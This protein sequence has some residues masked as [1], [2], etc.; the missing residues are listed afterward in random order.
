[1]VVCVVNF[2]LWPRKRKVP[3]D[4]AQGRLSTSFGCRLTARGMTGR[5]AGMTTGSSDDDG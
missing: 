2:T 5:K 4:Y 3:F 1:V